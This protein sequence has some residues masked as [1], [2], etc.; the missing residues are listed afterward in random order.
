MTQGLKLMFGIWLIFAFISLCRTLLYFLHMFQLN[1]YRTGEQLKWQLGNIPRLLPNLL[2]LASCA[3]FFLGGEVPATAGAALLILF[4]LLIFPATKKKETKKPLVFTPRVKRMTVTTCV[5]LLAAFCTGFYFMTKPETEYYGYVFSGAATALSPFLILIANLINKP[6]E[7]LINL[8]YTL[9]AKKMLADCPKLQTIGITGSYGKTSVKFYLYTILRGWTDVLVTPESYNTPMGI[10]KTVRTSLNAMHKIFLCEMGAKWVGD[11]KELCNIVHP[12]HGIITALG[13]QH[14]E[15]FGSVENIR[16]TKYELCNA[17]P[18]NGRLYLNGDCD[19]IRKNPPAHS[20]YYYGTGEDCDYRASDISVSKDGTAFTVTVPGG[21]SC[22]FN[23]KLLGAHN[24]LNIT[25]AIAAAH[26][27]G[28]PLN[29]MKLPVRRIEPVAH[30]MQLIEREN[31]T[32]IDDA[33]NSNPAGCRAALETL[34]AFSEI[35]VVVTPGMIELGEKQAE[36]NAEFGRQ[37]ASACDY[38]VLVG[39]KQTE[40]IAKGLAEVKFPE[41]RLFIEETL[42][43]AMA[44]VRSVKP[45]DKKVVLLENDLPDNY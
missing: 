8:R 18:E 6:M 41:N 38:C 4:S 10:V 24:V 27:F 22:R 16:K 20:Y 2:M 17:L 9:E 5:L 33:F 35:K 1:S 14:L 31:M 34:S 30:R 19:A 40:P 43:D 23:T 3:L 12:K 37:I 7:K 36:L 39:K 15:S 45:Y 29:S 13:E 21:E 44:R 25:G 42:T 11:I 26:G 32:V 28:M